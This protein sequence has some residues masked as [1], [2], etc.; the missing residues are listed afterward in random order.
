MTRFYRYYDL[1]WGH[2]ATPSDPK[3]RPSRRSDAVWPP[4]PQSTPPGGTTAIG[5]N[6]AKLTVR[7]WSRSQI[8]NS[9][10]G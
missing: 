6:K 2:A 3:A 8:R 1:E 9:V 7:S 4:T 5:V 10:R